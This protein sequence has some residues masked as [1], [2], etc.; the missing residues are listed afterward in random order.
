MAIPL[1]LLS[2]FEG[3]VF[4]RFH[5]IQYNKKQAK[6]VDI[7]E[8]HRKYF[9]PIN[10]LYR[11]F[12]LVKNN[13]FQILMN[14]VAASALAQIHLLEEESEHEGIPAAAAGSAE[15]GAVSDSPADMD[16]EPGQAMPEDPFPLLRPLIKVFMR[17]LRS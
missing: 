17:L 9:H 6:D 8:P 14:L 16:E 7:F 15:T 13:D 5:H 10:I 11:T 3:P 2:D 4:Q 12:T 1:H